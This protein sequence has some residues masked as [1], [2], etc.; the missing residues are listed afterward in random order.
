MG[1]IIEWNCFP[2][3]VYFPREFDR[4]RRNE[5]G[6]EAWEEPLESTRQVRTWMVQLTPNG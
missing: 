1:R 2:I 6:R 3:R 4:F 5:K